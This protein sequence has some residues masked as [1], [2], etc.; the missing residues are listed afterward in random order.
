MPP[1]L[2]ARRDELERAIEALRASKDD[3]TDEDAYYAKL[4]P[5]VLEL[6]RLYAEVEKS[7]ADGP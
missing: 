5:L 7:A 4:E 1:G 6:A 2:R 3:A